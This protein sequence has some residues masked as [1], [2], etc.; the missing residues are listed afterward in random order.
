MIRVVLDTNIL[1]S[2]L[3]SRGGNSDK[4][5]GMMLSDQIEPYFD[6]RIISEYNEVLRRKKF[7]FPASAVDLLIADI[8]RYGEPVTATT[9]PW[10]GLDPD[11]RCFYEV[12]QAA[13]AILITGNLKDF[14]DEPFIVN[15]R[16]FLEL[17]T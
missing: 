1:V 6:S 3:L 11:D 16:E 10:A 5:L 4:V 17:F 2:A 14:P 12:A 8:V 15:P 7:S 9:L 13:Q